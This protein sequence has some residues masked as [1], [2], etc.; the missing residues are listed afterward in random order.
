MSS[1]L[2]KPPSS[3]SSS[4]DDDAYETI[5][6]DAESGGKPEKMRLEHS[7]MENWTKEELLLEIQKLTARN[8]TQQLTISSKTH[9]ISELK[10]SISSLKT[11]NSLQK[12]ILEDNL[13]LSNRMKVLEAQ[14]TSEEDPEL[15]NL[16]KEVK[17]QKF[18]IMELEST[19][20]FQERTGLI[21]GL[22]PEDDGPL[23][24]IAEREMME[25]QVQMILEHEKMVRKAEKKKFLE[26]IRKLEEKLEEKSGSFGEIEAE[27][28][29]KLR[30]LDLEDVDDGLE[31]SDDVH[32]DYDVS[33]DVDGNS[34]ALESVA[35]DSDAPD[36]VN[37]KPRLLDD[38][39]KDLLA[40]E[41]AKK[42]SESL[43]DVTNDSEASD[44]FQNSDGF[45]DDSESSEST[46]EDYDPDDFRISDSEE[47]EN[48]ENSEIQ[49]TLKKLLAPKNSTIEIP[50]IDT[51]TIKR[52]PKKA[53]ISD[54]SEIQRLQNLLESKENVIRKLEFQQKKT[55]N[56]LKNR[57]LDV[58][59]LKNRLRILENI[60]E[61][62]NQPV[63]LDGVE[64][65]QEKLKTL[66]IDLKMANLRHE[67]LL[68]Q[69]QEQSGILEKLKIAENDKKRAESL[70]KE[71]EIQIE[72]I[73]NYQKQVE[74][75][76]KYIEDLKFRILTLEGTV[77]ECKK[78]TN[79]NLCL[80]ESRKEVQ[81][82]K[83]A[84]EEKRLKIEELERKLK[85]M[86]AN[87]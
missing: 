17:F 4:A 65:D 81:Y 70:L 12:S 47:S 76:N 56:R 19:I 75:D 9:R 57:D 63:N 73:L 35:K 36:D 39:T 8:D 30:I 38:V 45:D 28:V 58:E 29:K 86:E 33:D 53:E 18:K 82:L 6:I 48:S 26:E 21:L 84:L 40:A 51:G 41:A 60:L 46:Q 74:G 34:K 1:T 59:K 37:D 78:A 13:S 11:E 50:E 31:S 24:I 42:D 14:M 69:I 52:R 87:F 67:T 5:Q 32:K 22:D 20:K 10:T 66:K 16:R 27:I 72:T 54:K 62:S 2:R 43:E 7:K 44:E 83:G 64:I 77:E 15:E 25:E 71:A 79:S 49:E 68:E 55:E 3:E 23:A 85:E 80:Q 61:F